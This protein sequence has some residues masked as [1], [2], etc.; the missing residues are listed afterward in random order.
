M[1]R[2]G[3]RRINPKNGMKKI[4][5]TTL[6]CAFAVQQLA[7][8]QTNAPDATPV[9]QPDVT[10]NTPAAPAMSGD[11][12]TQSPATIVSNET[13]NAAMSNSRAMSA[14]SDQSTDAPTNPPAVPSIPLIQFQDVPLTT[15][16]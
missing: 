1:S 3:T 5:I 16:I 11:A 12:S 8:S 7:L 4:L 15:A 2:K 10:T 13:D 9:A 6:F 14:A